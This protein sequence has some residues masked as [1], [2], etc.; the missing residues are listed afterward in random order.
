M[1][2]ART[3]VSRTA[4]A[5]L[6][7]TALGLIALGLAGAVWA[8][9]T[10]PGAFDYYVLALSWSPTYCADTGDERND[11]QCEPRRERPYAFVLHGLWPQ[12]ER[13][14][15]RDCRSP[16]RGWVPRKV[17]RRMLDI[18][19]SEKLVFAEYRRHGTCSG[20]GVD[21]YFDL[22]RKLYDRVKVPPRFVNLTDDRMT[23]SLFEVVAD[24]VE[25]NPGLKPDML[26]VQCGGAGNRLKEVRVCFARTGEFRTC[27]RNEDQRR[28]CSADRLYVPPVRVSAGKD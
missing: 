2:P 5:R 14:A 22:A 24:F 4:I 10:E 16:D 20:L 13:G 23:V 6:A 28:L 12:Y 11:P 17:A 3:A 18:M 26:S 1:R 7:V 21:G 15:P 8:Q 19:P 25:A 9:R 27:G